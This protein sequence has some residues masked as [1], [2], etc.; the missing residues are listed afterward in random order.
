MVIKGF[1]LAVHAKA[2]RVVVMHNTLNMTQGFP[3]RSSGVIP[4]II[5]EIEDIASKAF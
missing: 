3:V 2:G 1:V 5:I 4:A